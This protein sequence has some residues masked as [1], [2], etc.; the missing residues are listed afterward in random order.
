MTFGLPERPCDFLLDSYE[1]ACVD[2]CRV[3][4]LNIVFVPLAV[5]YLDPLADAVGHI[6]VIYAVYMESGKKLLG[7]DREAAYFSKTVAR[8]KIRHSGFYACCAVFAMFP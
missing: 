6:S 2:D 1:G 7:Y 3:V 5:V 8:E 4:I